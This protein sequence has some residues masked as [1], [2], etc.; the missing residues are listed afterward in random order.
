MRMSESE[1]SVAA[2]GFECCFVP[3]FFAEVASADFF[4]PPVLRALLLAVLAGLFLAGEDG[5]A[6]ADRMSASAAETGGVAA[7]SLELFC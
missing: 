5:D 1:G 2:A 3:D 4:F 7:E 6:V